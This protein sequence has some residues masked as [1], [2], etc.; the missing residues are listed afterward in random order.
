MSLSSYEYDNAHGTGL[1]VHQQCHKDR[2]S[3]FLCNS[4]VNCVAGITRAQLYGGLRPLRA[5]HDSRRPHP[6]RP[7]RSLFRS[8]ALSA[9]FM[10]F[11]MRSFIGPLSSFPT[12]Q[13]VQKVSAVRRVICKQTPQHYEYPYYTTVDSTVGLSSP[14]ARYGSSGKPKQSAL[15]QATGAERIGKC[16]VSGLRRRRGTSPS[17]LECV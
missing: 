5:S 17:C 11:F 4:V 7:Q 1:P 10:A 12:L 3:L 13:S 15:A 6:S 9:T 8:S 14:I 2:L 16:Y